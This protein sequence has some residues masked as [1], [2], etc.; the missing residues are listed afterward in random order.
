M[1]L[2]QTPGLVLAFYILA[3]VMVVHVLHRKYPPYPRLL[4]QHGRD[5][6]ILDTVEAVNELQK[7]ALVQ[8]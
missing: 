2:V 6:K 7:Y 8:I 5:L 4:K 3:R 1:A